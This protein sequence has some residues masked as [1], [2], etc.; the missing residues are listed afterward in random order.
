[1]TGSLWHEA[2][3]VLLTPY[4]SGNGTFSKKIPSL[5]RSNRRQSILRLQKETRL[6]IQT[7]SSDSNSE[8]PLAEVWDPNDDGNFAPLYPPP[9]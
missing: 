3:E 2:H 7:L 9:L 6:S 1:M 4:F 5:A 8:P